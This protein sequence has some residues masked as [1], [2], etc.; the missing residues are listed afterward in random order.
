MNLKE[1]LLDS[2]RS[3][4]L[5]YDVNRDICMLV[6]IRVQTEIN[7][8]VFTLFP[9]TS[10]N[11]YMYKICSRL[12]REVLIVNFS[13]EILSPKHHLD[14]FCGIRMSFAFEFISHFFLM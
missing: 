8:G 4:Y 13:V 14:G 3:A 11:S 10:I 1:Q 6:A 7:F 2:K 9:I 12:F 5:A